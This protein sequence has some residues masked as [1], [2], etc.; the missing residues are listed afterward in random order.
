MF[1]IKLFIKNTLTNLFS[2]FYGSSRPINITDFKQKMA[3]PEFTCSLQHISKI[4]SNIFFLKKRNYTAS[5]VTLAFDVSHGGTRG[6]M[7][8]GDFVR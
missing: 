8:S 5:V 6:R 4:L 3:M 7:H 1:Y 2:T